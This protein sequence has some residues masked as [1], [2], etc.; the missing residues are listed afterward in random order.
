MTKLLS[1]QS[2]RKSAVVQSKVIYKNPAWL[3]SASMLTKASLSRSALRAWLP[4]LELE[5]SV[6]HRCPVTCKKETALALGHV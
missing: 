5:E 4:S 2:H 3:L 1:S 6:A